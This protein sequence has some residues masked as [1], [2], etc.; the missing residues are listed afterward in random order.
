MGDLLRLRNL[1]LLLFVHLAPSGARYAEETSTTAETIIQTADSL[2]SL[3]SKIK[4]IAIA[5]LENEIKRKW[6]VAGITREQRNSVEQHGTK[7]TNMEL[8]LTE[9][10]KS[11]NQ[12][13]Q[14]RQ[15]LQTLY[16][17][18]IRRVDKDDGISMRR[19]TTHVAQFLNNQGSQDYGHLYLTGYQS[20][21]SPGYKPAYT[22][23]TNTFHSADSRGYQ[24]ETFNDCGLIEILECITS[25][26]K[27]VSNPD[28]EQCIE[29]IMV[30][31]K[32]CLEGSSYTRGYQAGNIKDCGVIKFLECAGHLTT[33][34][35]Q[36]VH[37]PDVVQC[38]AEIMKEVVGCK[39]CVEGLCR[40]LGIDC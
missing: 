39:D 21:N 5:D 28:V 26:V 3:I 31:C 1:I 19:Q 11:E 32:D 17:Q 8:A 12:I 27:C 38:I 4:Y 23:N 9:L 36:C 6:N 16:T 33:A 34:I 10:Y 13:R 18:T 2:G 40:D 29:E 37:N 14:T 35:M 15:L 7:W 30:G 24:V 25:V 20:L 22:A